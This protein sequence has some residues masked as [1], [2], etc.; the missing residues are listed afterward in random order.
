MIKEPQ[1]EKPFISQTKIQTKT[2]SKSERGIVQKY[3][4]ILEDIPFTGVKHQIRSALNGISKQLQD[5]AHR[6]I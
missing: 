5:K 1:I 3:N 6:H 4:W 2:Q